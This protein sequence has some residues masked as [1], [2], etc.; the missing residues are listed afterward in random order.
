MKIFTKLKNDQIVENGKLYSFI[1]PYSY[2]ILRREN[3]LNNIDFLFVDGGLLSSM[4]TFSLGMKIPRVSFDMT[5]LAPRVFSNAELLGGTIYLVGS[6]ND[7]IKRAVINIKNSYPNLNI[8]GYRNGYFLG[9]E[10][11]NELDKISLI[12]PNILIVGMGAPIQEKFLIDCRN[13]GWTGTGFTCGGFFHQT[14]KAIQYYPEWIDRF[15]LR[16]LY[17]IYDEPKLLRRYLI[18]YSKFLVVFAYD[19]FKLK[20]LKS[21]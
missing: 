1:N 19:V 15:N 14:A 18:D 5:S 16:W 8:I 9:D 2:L 13:R 12:N 20:V 3:S 10:Y 7:E 4:L 17:R 21:R 6:K 11:V